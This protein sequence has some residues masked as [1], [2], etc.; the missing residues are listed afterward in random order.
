MSMSKL[1]WDGDVY[2]YWRIMTK[3]V[4]ES[5]QDG[6]LN[7]NTRN[8][9]GFSLIRPRSEVKVSRDFSW[10][11]SKCRS[12]PQSETVGFTEMLTVCV[13]VELLRL[14]G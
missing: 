6:Y 10:K 1:P 9:T 3:R 4:G 14:R 2:T 11:K 5:V 8:L 7:H 12:Q 13:D